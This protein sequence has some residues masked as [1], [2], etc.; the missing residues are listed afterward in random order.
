MNPPG[1]QVRAEKRLR[2]SAEERSARLLREVSGKPTATQPHSGAGGVDVVV[3][4]VV[5]VVVILV[6]HVLCYLLFLSYPL[7]FIIFIM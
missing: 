4:V 6:Y 5:V 2:E 7:L 1:C 3:V